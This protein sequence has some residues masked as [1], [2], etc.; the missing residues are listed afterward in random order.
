MDRRRAAGLRVRAA[1]RLRSR[2]VLPLRAHQLHPARPR[3]R[4]DHGEVGDPAVA[5]EL[6]RSARAQRHEDHEVPGHPCARTARLYVGARC[7]R[8]LDVVEPVVGPRQRSHHDLDAARHDHAHRGGRDAASC[9]RSPQRASRSSRFRRACRVRR[10]RSTTGSGSPSAT[11]GCSRTRSS[12]ATRGFCVPPV[13]ADLDPDR[14]HARPERGP[15]SSIATDIFKA[16]HAV[17]D[18]QRSALVQASSRRRGCPATTSASAVVPV[19]DPRTGTESDQANATLTISGTL[20]CTS[21]IRVGVRGFEPPASTSR[22][23]HA[24]QAALHPV[25]AGTL[26]GRCSARPAIGRLALVSARWERAP[27]GPAPRPT[28]SWNV[29]PPITARTARRR[30]SGSSGLTSQPSAPLRRARW[31]SAKRSSSTSSGMFGTRSVDSSRRWAMATAMPPIE[32]ICRSRMPMSRR[33]ARPT[34]LAT[35]RPSDTTVKDVSASPSAATPRR[36]PSWRPWPAARASAAIVATAADWPVVRSGTRW[37]RTSVERGEVVDVA[38][39]QRD[40][41][42]RLVARAARR[43]APAPA[44]RLGQV[45][46][47]ATLLHSAARRRRRRRPRQRRC[48]LGGR[49]VT[50]PWVD[51]VGHAGRPRRCPGRPA[52]RRTTPPRSPFPV[53]RGDDDVSGSMSAA[54]ADDHSARSRNP[55]SMPAKAWKKATASASTS[56][57]TT[58]PIARSIGCV[59][60]S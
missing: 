49:A 58:R 16:R 3:G 13:A 17:P 23:W 7:L 5:R 25:A 22:T 53:R 14:E 43:T 45:R 1:D 34:T 4:A 29:P 59:A 20:G 19:R 56:E 57:P 30:R 26:P 28:P 55:A 8:G 46:S 42:E 24:N 10:R 47:S 15:G 51:P 37:R 39:E 11:V 50:E 40:L 38:G 32:P 33:R 41:T 6:P 52:G 44:R 12:T 35:S 9:S 31:T 54:A 36:P 18:A 27:G 21:E 60:A 2:H 48:G